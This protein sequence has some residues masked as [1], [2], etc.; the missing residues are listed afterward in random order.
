[1]VPV[2]SEFKYCFRVEWGF[3][4]KFPGPRLSPRRLAPRSLV[5]HCSRH[6]L[7]CGISSLQSNYIKLEVG[8][9]TSGERYAQVTFF[10]FQK[11][12]S[13]MGSERWSPTS[14]STPETA[15]PTWCLAQGWSLKRSCWISFWLGFSSLGSYVHKPG[16]RSLTAGWE[17]VPCRQAFWEED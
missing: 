13:W 5:N 8:A 3:A 16:I 15:G 4:A 14:P 2:V 12:K 10:L 6:W 17:A 11:K 9:P 1:M 7:C